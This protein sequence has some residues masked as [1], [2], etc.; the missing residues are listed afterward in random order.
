VATE[1]Q[2]GQEMLEQAQKQ[3]RIGRGVFVMLCV[4]GFIMYIDRTNI[5]VVAP[6]LKNELQ[7]SNTGLGFVFSA[8]AVAYAVFGIPGAWLTDRIGSRLGMTLFGT[9]WSVATIATAYAGSIFGLA[10]IRFLVGVGEA[11]IYASAAR[12]IATW[13]PAHRRGAAQ[14][15]MH[16]SGRFANA[17]A[18]LVISGL[19]IAF[20][21]RDTFV[22]LGVITL[23]F[24]A[25]FY[26]YIRDNPRTD[27]RVSQ[28]ELAGLGLLEPRAPAAEIVAKAPV[29]WPS[30]LRRVWPATA[31]CFCHGW[32]L[33]FFNNWIPSYFVIRYHMKIEQ[34]ALFASLV[35][36]GGTLGTLSGGML[37]DWRFRRTGNRLRSRRDVIIFGFLTSIIGLV[38]LLISNNL[39]INAAGLG[40]AFFLSELSDSPLWL[41]GAEVAPQH[42]AT[43]SA[44]VFAGMAL[45]GAISPIVIGRLLDISGGNWSIAF[46]A[47]IV[48]LLLGPVFAS[49]IRLDP[50]AESDHSGSYPAAL[51]KLAHSSGVN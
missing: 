9:L 6:L 7:L 32:V 41:V 33:W 34:P 21:W 14:G 29:H 16:A 49:M 22:A 12:V 28:S 31:A 42:A 1:Q 45:A 20:P 38:P 37:A 43:S 35:L 44:I 3:S 24:F 18:P 15:A 2:S 8:F 23:I 47:S 17:V 19:M 10:T 30:L 50:R 11:P 51:K 4:M 13:I 26:W 5:S 39:A 27:P 40:I 36:L 48:V 25:V 46:I